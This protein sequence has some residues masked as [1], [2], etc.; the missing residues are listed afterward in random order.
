MPGLD[1]DSARDGE[2]VANRDLLL[3]EGFAQDL[4]DENPGTFGAPQQPHQLGLIAAATLA[5]FPRRLPGYHARHHL[6]DPLSGIRR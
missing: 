5:R 3:V 4:L 1:R 2:G 6:P